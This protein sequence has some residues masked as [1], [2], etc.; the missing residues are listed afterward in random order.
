MDEYRLSKGSP[1]FAFGGAEG[2]AGGGKKD[3]WEAG[4]R[5][6]V[7]VSWYR[8]DDDVDVDSSK[9]MSGLTRLE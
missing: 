3:N 2:F 9:F 8:S 1:E 4:M 6:I 7:E 5:R